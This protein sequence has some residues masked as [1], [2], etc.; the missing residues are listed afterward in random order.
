MK[1]EEKKIQNEA[2]QKELAEASKE[3]LGK[4]H[5]KANTALLDVGEIARKLGFSDCEIEKLESIYKRTQ[6]QK[7]TVKGNSKS[8]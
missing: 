2:K 5:K 6:K 1:I 3:L 8:N 4:R 7:K